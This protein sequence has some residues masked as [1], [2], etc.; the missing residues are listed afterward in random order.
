[1]TRFAPL[2]LAAYLTNYEANGLGKVSPLLLSSAYND[3]ATSVRTPTTEYREMLLRA[4]YS[5][6]PSEPAIVKNLGF[7]LEQTGRVEE[8]EAMYIGYLDN[9]GE[10]R[11]IRVCLACLCPPHHATVEEVRMWKTEERSD[12]LKCGGV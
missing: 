7:L 12:E 6:S 11:G 8:A 4:A 3:L 9:Y 10:E 2:S 1:M 5:R